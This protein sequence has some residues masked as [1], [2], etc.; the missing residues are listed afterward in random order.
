MPLIAWDQVCRPKSRGGLGLRKTEVVNKVFQCKLAWK[1]L[2]NVP[3]LWVQ[4]MRAKYLHST[5]LF[6]CTRKNTDS[7]VWKSLLKCRSLLQT[8]IIWKIGRGDEISFWFDN[9]FENRTLVEIL[10]VSEDS[11]VHPEVKV[12]EF[13]RDNSE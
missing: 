2:T 3:S 13:I 4:S 7:P 12:C 9:W 6:Y 5:N 8:G 11:I 10:G 1:I